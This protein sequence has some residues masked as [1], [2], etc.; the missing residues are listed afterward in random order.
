MIS[1]INKYDVD[2]EAFKYIKL[3]VFPVHPK[4]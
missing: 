2:I 3:V 4:E 1:T